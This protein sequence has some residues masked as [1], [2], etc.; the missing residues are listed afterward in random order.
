MH[1]TYL[2]PWTFGELNT[3]WTCQIYW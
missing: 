3:H 2:Q 1:V